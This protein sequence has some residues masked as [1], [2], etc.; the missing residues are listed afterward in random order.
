MSRRLMYCQWR[1]VDV[2]FFFFFLF[3]SSNAAFVVFAMLKHRS[4]QSRFLSMVGMTGTL[5]LTAYAHGA[6]AYDG[7]VTLAQPLNHLVQQ[8]LNIFCTFTLRC[9][10]QYTEVIWRKRFREIKQT[11]LLPPKGRVRQ[12]SCQ[13][14][15]DITL[16]WLCNKANAYLRHTQSQ[17]WSACL[18]K[19]I[20]RR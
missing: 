19:S 7:F 16:F 15:T 12:V 17:P 10:S 4:F 18:Q 11:L 1:P 6:N 5:I 8:P 20:G 3:Q 13:S 2:S 14:K 9:R